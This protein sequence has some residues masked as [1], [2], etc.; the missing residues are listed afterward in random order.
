MARP[1]CWEWCCPP[2]IH[3]KVLLY[4]MII[5]AQTQ[6]YA[7]LRY[8]S[9][10]KHYNQK[11][12]MKWWSWWWNDK[13]RPLHNELLSSFLPVVHVKPLGSTLLFGAGSQ[14]SAVMTCGLQLSVGVS[15]VYTA[16]LHVEHLY[17]R[18]G[19]CSTA[20]IFVPTQSHCKWKFSKISN[21]YLHKS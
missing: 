12:W 15:C 20:G 8:K 1:Q 19:S 17:I 21:K 2:R 5:T 9:K 11:A 3:I 10:E 6:K 4:L 18:D 13:M 14:H 16:L 7:D